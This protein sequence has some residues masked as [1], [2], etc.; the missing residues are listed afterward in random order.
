MKSIREGLKGIDYSNV[1]EMIVRQLGG[2]KFITMTGAKNFVQSKT[3]KYITF[4]LP[5]NFAKG[6]INFVKIQLTPLDTYNIDFYKTKG[7]SLKKIKS[8]KNI[9]A[10]TLRNIFEDTTGLKTSLFTSLF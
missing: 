10:D 2:N 1:G 3:E 8:Y 7:M 4:K 9:Y 5:S 6:G